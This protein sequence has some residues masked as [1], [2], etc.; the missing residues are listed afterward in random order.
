VKAEF[1]AIV[2]GAG[3]VGNPTAYFLAKEG[4]R[5]IVLDELSASGQGQNKAAIGGVRAT[6]SDPAKIR[7]CQQSLE[8]FSSWKESTGT[9]IGWKKGG[10][11]F[12]AFDEKVEATVKGLLPIQQEY[13]LNIDWHDAEGIER[14]VPGINPAGLR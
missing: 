12:P 10:Y 8:V 5:P 11:C 2:I 4:L 6:H 1:D 14:I 9:D 3:S 7:L 13:H